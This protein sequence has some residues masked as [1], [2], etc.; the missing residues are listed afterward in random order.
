MEEIF[1]GTTDRFGYYQVGHQKIYSKY[2]A[3]KLHEK[4]GIHP[5]WHFHDEIFSCYNWRQEPTESLT[6][7]YRRRAEQLR[8]K[9]DYIVLFF[10]GGA[11]ST[12]VLDSF[13]NN[14]IHLDEIVSFHH[15]LGNQNRFTHTDAEVTNVAIPRAQRA[16]ER[17]PNTKFSLI[18]LSTYIYD[19]YKSNRNIDYYLQNMITINGRPDTVKYKAYELEP[20]FLDLIHSGRRVCFLTGQD[21]PRIHK[22]GDKWTFKFIDVLTVCNGGANTPVEYFYWSADLPELI[23]KQAHTVKRY[24]ELADA[25]TPFVT[26]KPKGGNCSKEHNGQTLYLTNHGVHS[27]IYPSWDIET[28]TVAKAVSLIYG[29]KTKWMQ[30]DQLDP[31]SVIWRKIIDSWWK[32]VP[33]YW[34]NDPTDIHKGIKGMWSKSYELN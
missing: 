22:I 18:D 8:E 30:F 10:S 27:L 25:S 24:L 4:T 23:I 34:K 19:F 5:E 11:D 21:K 7:L 31:V 13:I 9:Y 6:E 29:E 2:D 33:D 26:T 1:I 14:N 28:F 17:S 32:S 20:T 3:I 15:Y 16:L 12:T